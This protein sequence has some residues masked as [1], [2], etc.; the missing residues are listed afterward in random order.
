M[1]AAHEV[2]RRYYSYPVRELPHRKSILAVLFKNLTSVEHRIKDFPV[3]A[4]V[5]DHEEEVLGRVG[6]P[7][8][9]SH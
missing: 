5:G 1:T 9:S 3:L 2:S 6:D 4:H 8:I 7:A